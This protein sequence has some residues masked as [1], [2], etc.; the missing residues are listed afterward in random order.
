MIVLRDADL[1]RAANDGRLLGDGERRPD[2]PVGRARV[3]RGAGLR[4]VRRA[5]S[6]RGRRRSRQGALG[7][8]RLGRRRR[9]H[10]REPGG[11]RR[12]P[13]QGRGRQGREDPHGRQAPHEGAGRFFEPTVLVDVDHSMEFMTEE[14]FGPTLP[15]MKV[16]DEDEAVRLA[17]DSP[18]RAQLERLHAGTSRR[19][20]GSRG[21]SGRQ[22][23][24]ERHDHQ[25][26]GAGAAVRRQ[27]RV[28][29]RRAPRAA[30]IQKYCS[31]Q[32]ILVHALRT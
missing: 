31:A 32:T 5:R 3:R 26:H 4:R 8:D 2:L 18:L 27:R 30:G 10:V 17:N 22:R 29:D 19:A 20:S 24:R 23:L 25:L 21:G 11:D 9:D 12:A 15:I 1:E 7:R 13:R 16:R 14:T 28:R 6:S